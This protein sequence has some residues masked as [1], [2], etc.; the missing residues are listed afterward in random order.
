PLEPVRH[1][2]GRLVLDL[3]HDHFHE[4]A[5]LL[6][7]SAVV[8]TDYSSVYIDALYL[9]LPVLGFAYDLEHYRD[10]QN[11]LL[12]DLDLAFPGPVAR[13]FLDLL[14]ALDRQLARPTF[15]PDEHYR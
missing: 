4:I 2:D 6:R 3:G 1:L 14:E 10:H 12:Y 15:E 5:P 9:D 7:Q 11:G 13:T 8:V